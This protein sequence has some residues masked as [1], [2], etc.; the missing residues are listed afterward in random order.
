MTTATL[1]D[2]A[3]HVLGFDELEGTARVDAI[4]D[5]VGEM[6]GRDPAHQMELI[7]YARSL[8]EEIGYERGF[9]RATGIRGRVS[10]LFSRHHEAI[11]DLLFA[12]NYFDQADDRTTAALNRG[13]LAALYSSQGNYEE[14]LSL[15]LE[16]LAVA[17]ESGDAEGVGWVLNGLSGAYLELGQPELAFKRGMEALDS[18]IEQGHPVGQG[19]AHSSVG[20]VLRTMGRHD[21]A[22]GHHE[23]SLRLFQ[24]DGDRLGESRAYHDLGL[25]A[26]EQEEFDLALEF[27]KTAL[28]IRREIDNRQSVCT[29]LI[30]IGRTL[31]RLGRS[32]EAMQVLKEPC[33]IA[34]DL[35][36]RPKLFAAHLALAETCEAKG[37]ARAALNHYRRYQEIHE[38]VLGAQATGQIRSMQARYEAEQAQQKAELERLRNVELREKNEQLEK[39]LAE[40][41]KAQNRLVQSEKLASLGRVTSG[42]AHEIKNPLNFVINFAELNVELLADLG[43]VL[44]ERKTELPKDIVAMFADDFETVSENIARVIENAKRADGIV[45][46]ML[47]HV[48]HTGGTHRPTDVNALLKESVMAAFGGTDSDEGITISWDID[49]KVETIDLTAQSMQRVFV[50]VLDNARYSILARSRLEE[51][52]FVPTIAIKTKR[53]PG[54]VQVRITDNGFGIPAENCTRIF[55]PFYTTKPTGE[56]TGL[57]LSLA[58]DIVTQGH[59]GSM[60]AISKEG[61]GATLVVTLPEGET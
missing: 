24:E 41:Q 29:S 20:T 11:P 15:A 39:L 14:A 43:A 47:G 8:A 3:T 48:R 38:E 17:R 45:R 16:N 44:E 55:E 59:G 35:E 2:I 19:R 54:M 57:G 40:L 7:D 49:P 36:L 21:E 58:Y 12:I 32:D 9:A 33:E 52:G 1:D 10:F 4:A 37:D 13:V 53:L 31:T 26:F 22:T 46:S 27:H 60:A 30:E 61:E 25:V 28:A 34:E 6:R 5:Y 56:G 18:F 51:N 50:N 23:I 42:I